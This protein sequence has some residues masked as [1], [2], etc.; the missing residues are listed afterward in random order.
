MHDGARMFYALRLL[1]RIPHLQA[2]VY[3]EHGHTVEDPDESL[4][5]LVNSSE[6][7]WQLDFQRSRVTHYNNQLKQVN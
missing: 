3:D 5:T 7:M 4:S 1:S 6:M 2:V